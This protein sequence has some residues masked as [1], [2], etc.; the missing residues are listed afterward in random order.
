MC[1]CR[2]NTAAPA[3]S[4]CGAVSLKPALSTVAHCSSQEGCVSS[5]RAHLRRERVY[6]IF[7]RKGLTFVAGRLGGVS[8]SF[9]LK[10]ENGIL[11]LV[12]G[13]GFRVGESN[14]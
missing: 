1:D 5:P 4:I 6:Q 13:S 14:F 9:E 8:W 3:N 11:D 10:C 2:N 7:F 12:S